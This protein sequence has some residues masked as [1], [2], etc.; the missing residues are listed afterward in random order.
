M[1]LKLKGPIAWFGVG[2]LVHHAA[3]V[4]E[5]GRV[6]YAGPS[7]AA[8]PA[9]EFIEVDGFLMPGGADRTHGKRRQEREGR[10][11]LRLRS[12]RRRQL[13]IERAKRARDRTGQPR[14]A[15]NRMQRRAVESQECARPADAARAIAVG[16]PA[17]RPSR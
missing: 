13:L 15:R 17:R 1:P 6:T 7:A 5:G 11:F 16:P 14:R 4:C 3:V 10:E 12:L 8:P 9:D 2:P